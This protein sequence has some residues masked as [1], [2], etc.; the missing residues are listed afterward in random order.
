M[1][2][3]SLTKVPGLGYQQIQKLIKYFGSSQT[4]WEASEKDIIL[5][6]LNKGICDKLLKMR[7]VTITPIFGRKN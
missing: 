4:V 5:S 1:F 2:L 3:I 6:C 7:G